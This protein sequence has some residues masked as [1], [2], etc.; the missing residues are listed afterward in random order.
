MSRNVTIWWLWHIQQELLLSKFLKNSQMPHKSAYMLRIWLKMALY[1]DFDTF[2]NSCVCP[3][4]QK[5]HKMPINQYKT[6]HMWPKSCDFVFWHIQQEIYFPR[7]LKTL[8]YTTNRREYW[9]YT[10]ETRDL[11][12]LYILAKDV[13]FSEPKLFW[14]ISDFLSSKFFWDLAQQLV[15]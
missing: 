3:N 2:G 11:A 13:S 15:L 4:S 5:H 14:Q 7:F 9:I 6:L 10:P 8:K 1:C 12:I